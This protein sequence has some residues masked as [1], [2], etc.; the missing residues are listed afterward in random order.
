[1]AGPLNCG[2]QAPC[3]GF[4]ACFAAPPERTVTDADVEAIAAR[5]FYYLGEIFGPPKPVEE[6]EPNP[7]DVVSSW[8]A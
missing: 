1:M 3:G 4:C 5:V 2:R 7:T 6:P 8:G